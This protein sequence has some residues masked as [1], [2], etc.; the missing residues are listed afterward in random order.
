MKTSNHFKSEKISLAAVVLTFALMHAI[1][2][3][4]SLASN[5]TIT[6][7]SVVDFAITFALLIV[8]DRV[9]A[10]TMPFTINASCILNINESTTVA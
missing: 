6:P 4:T 2:V 9:D 3:F 7:S 10:T 5:N 8:I 1:I